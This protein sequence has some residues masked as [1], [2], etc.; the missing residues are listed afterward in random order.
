MTN[1][2]VE[3]PSPPSVDIGNMA[4]PHYLEASVV[5]ELLNFRLV[6]KWARRA[7][8]GTKGP[9]GDK[10]SIGKLCSSGAL[11]DVGVCEDHPY[12]HKRHET[13][14]TQQGVLAGRLAA[15]DTLKSSYLRQS[16]QFPGVWLDVSGSPG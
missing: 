7:E 6:R 4:L 5:L 2:G 16:S 10:P 11:P 13:L 15:R 9:V 8:R 3:F 12:D 1:A 14:G